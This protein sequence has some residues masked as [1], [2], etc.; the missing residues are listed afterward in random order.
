L[1]GL[2]RLRFRVLKSADVTEDYN[3]FDDPRYA[4]AIV[5]V[6][7]LWREK[8]RQAYCEAEPY[9]LVIFDEA[10]KL[11]ARLNADLTISVAPRGGARA[12]L[13]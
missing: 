9:E 5:S 4:L 7:T 13:V 1:E 8:M 3:P 6:D 10:H 11:A 12:G 2:F